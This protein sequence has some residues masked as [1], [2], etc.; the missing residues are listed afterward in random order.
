VADD[1]GIGEQPLDVSRTEARDPVE[2]EFGERPSE[3]LA[4]AENREPGETGL[5]PFEAELLEEPPVVGD[6]KAP[7]TVVVRP[8]FGRGVSPPAADDAVLGTREA[9]DGSRL[10]SE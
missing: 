2:V 7:F 3:P 4:L 9:F 10:S 8:V 6:R 1:P 5:E